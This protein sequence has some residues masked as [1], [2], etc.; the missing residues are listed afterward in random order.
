ML[1]TLSVLSTCSTKPLSILRNDQR[2]IAGGSNSGSCWRFIVLKRHSSQNPSPRQESPGFLPFLKTRR[3]AL[4]RDPGRS[5]GASP[6]NRAG[7]VHSSVPQAR[8]G[9]T[10][11][12]PDAGAT[13][14][15]PLIPALHG[16]LPLASRPYL[17]RRPERA[18]GPRERCL[19]AGRH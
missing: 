7:A 6:A 13:G 9:G 12:G 2:H 1:D 10:G 16:G 11:P 19:A 14:A 4:V 5:V 3:F 15:Q 8:P 17:L 18:G